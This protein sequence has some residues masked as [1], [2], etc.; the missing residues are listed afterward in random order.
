LKTIRFDLSILTLQYPV[1]FPDNG[2]GFS[3]ILI[4]F[5]FEKFCKSDKI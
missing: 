4:V 2:S 1:R 5:I 3:N